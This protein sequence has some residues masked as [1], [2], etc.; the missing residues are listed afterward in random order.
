MRAHIIGVSV[1]DTTAETR[2]VTESVIA[3][4]RKSRPTMSPM[5]RSGISTAIK[6]TVR[7]T[8]VKPICSEPLSAACSG[9]SPCSM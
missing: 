1:N 4:S 8:I 7:D 3:N 5:K 2:I 6:D 9:E